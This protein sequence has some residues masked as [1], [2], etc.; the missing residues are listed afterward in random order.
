M[1]GVL[2][3]AMPLIRSSLSIILFALSLGLWVTHNV[4]DAIFT[5]VVALYIRSEK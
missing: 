3:V 2:L 5:G 1:P 4:A